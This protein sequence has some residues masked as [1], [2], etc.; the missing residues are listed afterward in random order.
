MTIGIACTAAAEVALIGQPIT[1]A[2][3][4]NN[5]GPALPRGV[6]ISSLVSGTSLPTLDSGT[7]TIPGPFGAGT[8]FCSTGTYQSTC[9]PDSVPVAAATP[10][11]ITTIGRPATT[12]LFTL[13]SEV[14]TTSTDPDLTDNAASATLEVFLSVVIDVSPKDPTNVVN[15]NRGGTVTVAILTTDTFNATTIDPLTVCFG[16]ADAPSERTCTEQ[17]VTGHLEDVNKDK[18]P[19]LLLHF[20]VEDTGIDMGDTSACMRAKTTAGVG[21]F[22]CEAI[23]TKK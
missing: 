21:L 6:G 20:T 7:W 2:T 12:G 5:L 18:R 9:S 11:N 10:V 23:T 17:H 22:G 8:F 15:L 3:R 13:R 19:D 4:L 1:C 16:D 14:T